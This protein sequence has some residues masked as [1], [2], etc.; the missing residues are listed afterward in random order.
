LVG[1]VA[2]GIV[3]NTMGGG[4]GNTLATLAGVGLGAAA[5]N[6]IEQKA[7]N[8]QGVEIEVRLDGGESIVVTQEN[9]DRE[10]FYTGDRV[11]VIMGG[12]R[13]RVTH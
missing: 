13:T 4:R 9:T 12:G 3:G 8:R 10:S 6:A 7:T 11:R 1:A 2:G 5:G